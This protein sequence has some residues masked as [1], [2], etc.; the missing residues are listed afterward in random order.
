M[1]DS[2]DKAF[3]DLLVLNLCLK[4]IHHF[5]PGVPG[6]NMRKDGDQ[7]ASCGH[8][9]L[10]T[11]GITEKSTVTSKALFDACRAGHVDA[12]RSIVT[13][14]EVDINSTDPYGWR[15]LHFAALHNRSEAVSLL[16]KLGAI[17]IRTNEG[18]SSTDMRPELFGKEPDPRPVPDTMRDVV[19]ELFGN[20]MSTY[21]LFSK[22]MIGQLLRMIDKFGKEFFIL[23]ELCNSRY[24]IHFGYGFRWLWF[25]RIYLDLG[26]DVNTRDSSGFTALH[27][28][29]EDGNVECAK[30]LMEAGAD[31]NAMDKIGRSALS[32]TWIF[33]KWRC[34]RLLEAYQEKEEEEEEE[35]EDTVEPSAK[36]SRNV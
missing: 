31:M 15:A 20:Y 2:A 8:W 35:E 28:A 30:L 4:R 12:I 7:C 18:I 34:M 6:E 13:H 9:S 33:K 24:F 23:P 1:T 3:E 21:D 27:I 14:Y 16:L 26:M 29:C 25:C 5:S 17:D 22:K 19:D 36:R 10:I 32:V 11:A